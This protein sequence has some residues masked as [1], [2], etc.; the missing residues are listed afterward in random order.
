M[1]VSYNYLDTLLGYTAESGTGS[2]NSTLGGLN[3]TLAE[4]SNSTLSGDEELDT[5]VVSRDNKH[6]NTIFKVAF[7]I[8]PPESLTWPP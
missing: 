7:N 8:R 6:R 4:D 1:L 3:E 2:S 5:G